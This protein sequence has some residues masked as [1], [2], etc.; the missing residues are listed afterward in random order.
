MHFGEHPAIDGYDGDLNLLN[1]EVRVAN[2]LKSF[3]SM[4][5]MHVLGVPEVVPTSGNHEKDPGGIS[6]F[7]MIEESHISINTF[8]KRDF[9]SP[10]VYTCKNVL[11]AKVIEKNLTTKDTEGDFTKKVVLPAIEN[12]MNL[13]GVKPL[14]VPIEPIEIDKPWI[15]Y[16]PGVKD[17]ILKK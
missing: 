11:G 15:S 3:V 16:H 10:D 14:I 13:F 17:I 1:D 4:L 6:G 9:I 2:A 7:T 8:T 12:V 5:D